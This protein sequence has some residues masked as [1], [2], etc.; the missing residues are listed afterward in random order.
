MGFMIPWGVP[1]CIAQADLRRSSGAADVSVFG[2]CCPPVFLLILR[3]CAQPSQSARSH[4][5]LAETC[6][7]KLV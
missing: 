3:S 2:L 5:A 6:I 4:F 1:T 7:Q